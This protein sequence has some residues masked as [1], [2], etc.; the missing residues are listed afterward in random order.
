M[1][2]AVFRHNDPYTATNAPGNEHMRRYLIGLGILMAFWLVAI[3]QPPQ[4]PV[5]GATPA[6]T[7]RIIDG[8]R[9][10]LLY[11]VPK[12]TQGSWVS[13]CVDPKG[14]LIT[15]DQYG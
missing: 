6:N 2:M 11:T 15:S 7:I 13:M 9:I 1:T 3:A 12:E 4:K 14:R 8:F 5:V 10:E